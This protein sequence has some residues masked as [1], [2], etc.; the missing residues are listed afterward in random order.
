MELAGARQA[1]SLRTA[2][3]SSAPASDASEIGYIVVKVRNNVA[4]F[5]FCLLHVTVCNI[6]LATKE[7]EPF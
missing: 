2:L 6:V 3:P 7:K 5:T 4:I 1:H